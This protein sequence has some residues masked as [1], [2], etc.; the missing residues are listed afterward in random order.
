MPTL[1]TRTGSR[2]SGSGVFPR[3]R[4]SLV[5]RVVDPGSRAG[6]GTR[7]GAFADLVSAY[8]RP[9][10]RALRVKHRKQ[11]EEAEDLTQ[12]FFLKLLEKSTLESFVADPTAGRFRNL[13]QSL[14]ERFVSTANRDARRQ[15]RGGHVRKVSLDPAE[16]EAIEG[17]IADPRPYLRRAGG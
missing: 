17:R 14:L 1:Y 8:W 13:L 6:T 11:R 7:R 9:V 4:W 15:K 12:T 5:A 16:I 2:S 10:Y 3:T